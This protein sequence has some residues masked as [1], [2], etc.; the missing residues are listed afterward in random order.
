MTTAT[1]TTTPAPLTAI[2]F[3]T[4]RNPRDVFGVMGIWDTSID[5]PDQAFA[6]Q[7]NNLNGDKIDA[8]WWSMS[9]GDIWV[10]AR[11]GNPAD[12]RYM[13]CCSCGW[14]E[15]TDEQLALWLRE[16]PRDRRFF[17]SDHLR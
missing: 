10:D 2:Y 3:A 14:R 8:R 1:A 9:V 12:T 7:G 13:L 17:E 6:A 4:P 15:L 11:G 16:E 5:T